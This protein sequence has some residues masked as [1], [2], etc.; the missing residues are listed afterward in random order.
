M[1]VIL[2]NTP[3]LP[4]KVNK[5][6]NVVKTMDG[7]VNGTFNE[8]NPVI[9]FKGGVNNINYAKINGLYY[10]I[11]GVEYPSNGIMTVTF[12]MDLLMSYKDYVLNLTG[13]IES[14]SSDL[15]YMPQRFM[16]DPNLVIS[17]TLKRD[18]IFIDHIP[19]DEMFGS[20]IL[21]VNTPTLRESLEG[22][23]GE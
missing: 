3:S 12:E 20:Y 23:V 6:F 8:R 2:G 21:A 10:Y 1:E 4:N 7:S 15:G 11:V 22:T 13:L 18:N 17:K 16:E 14:S 19:M 9:N 5:T